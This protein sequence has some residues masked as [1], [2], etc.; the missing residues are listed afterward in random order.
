MA[1]LE[2]KIQR[3]VAFFMNVHA[4]FIFDQR[5]YEEGKQ[6]MV[7]I[8]RLNELM[9]EA[10]KEAYCDA[11][12]DY[13]PTLWASKLHFHITGVPFYNFQY[14]FGYLFGLVIYAYA[15]KQDEGFEVDYITLLCDTVQMT[16]EEVAMK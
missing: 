9:E 7:P 13:D 2:D 12:T 8:Y 10:Q 1:L 16:M 15:K 6:G 11:V 5:F 4:R 3:S 14:T